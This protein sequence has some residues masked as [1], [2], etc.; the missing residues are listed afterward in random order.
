MA[1]HIMKTARA[2]LEASRGAGGTPTRMLYFDD[3]FVQQDVKTV[4]PQQLRRSY[5]GFY[6]ATAG[7]ETNSLGM[8]GILSFDDLVWLANTHI[9]AVAAGTGGGADKT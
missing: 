2:V 4:R 7:P 9:K 3:G 1:L 5:N 6:S 8:N